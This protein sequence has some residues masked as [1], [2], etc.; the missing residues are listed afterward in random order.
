MNEQYSRPTAY[1]QIIHKKGL[2]QNSIAGIRVQTLFFLFSIDIKSFQQ[3]VGWQPGNVE[4]VHSARPL[5]L[6][7][8]DK[9]LSNTVVSVTVRCNQCFQRMNRLVYCLENVLGSNFTFLSWSRN[10]NS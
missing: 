1:I 8:C 5:C 6:V 4:H 2:Q 3:L 7:L 9:G 10:N